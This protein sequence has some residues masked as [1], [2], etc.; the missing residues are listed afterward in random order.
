M[1][2]DVIVRRQTVED[3]FSAISSVPY[4]V[5]S[6]L[7]PFMVVERNYIHDTEAVTLTS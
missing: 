1:K 5:E 4:A 3:R 6:Y 7:R 2:Q